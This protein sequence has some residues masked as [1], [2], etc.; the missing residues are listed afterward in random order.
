MKPRKRLELSPGDPLMLYNAGCFYAQLGEKKLAI[1]SIRNA[2]AAGYAEF[3]WLKRDSDL[4][5]I[6]NEPEFLE[7]IKG[8]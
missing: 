5:N 6:K 2:I 8:K 4:E 3:E 1:D 7:L